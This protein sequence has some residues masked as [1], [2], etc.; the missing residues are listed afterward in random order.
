VFDRFVARIQN[1]VADVVAS[2]IAWRINHYCEKYTLVR[3]LD[4]VHFGASV[5]WLGEI[6][7]ERGRHALTVAHH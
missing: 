2:V 4:Q 6:V 5:E 7:E 1:T 3:L